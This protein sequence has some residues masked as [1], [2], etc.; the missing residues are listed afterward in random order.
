M[1]HSH[2][3]ARY[4]I[5]VFTGAHHIITMIQIEYYINFAGINRVYENNIKTHKR[6]RIYRPRIICKKT[7][8]ICRP[9]LEINTK[10]NRN[11][12]TVGNIPFT[13]VCRVFHFFGQVCTNIFCRINVIVRTKHKV[14]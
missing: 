12:K 10:F 11:A 3:P 9:F 7:V 2:C 5:G 8:G 13:V 14:P 1:Q 6:G 4:C